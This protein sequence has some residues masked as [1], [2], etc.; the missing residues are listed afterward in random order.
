MEASLAAKTDEAAKSAAELSSLKVENEKVQASSAVSNEAEV[1]LAAIKQKLTEKEKETVRL[2]E[3]NERL[4]E[5]V[6]TI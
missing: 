1:E 4:S 6:G 3:E 2:M 5:Q